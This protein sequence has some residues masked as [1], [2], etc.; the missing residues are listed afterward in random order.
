MLP[1]VSRTTPEPTPSPSLVVTLM[2]TT[3]GSAFWATAFASVVSVESPELTV[4]VWLEDVVPV[5][6]VLPDVAEEGIATKPPTTSTATTAA[7]PIT[8]PRRPNSSER[9]PGCGFLGRLGCCDWEAWGRGPC[10]GTGAPET[11]VS[12]MSTPLDGGPRPRLLSLSLYPT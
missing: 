10:G 12:D 9:R 5:E 3:E 11:N 1:S 6:P 7:A 4:T 2:E 8:P